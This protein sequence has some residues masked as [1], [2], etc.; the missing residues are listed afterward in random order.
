MYTSAIAHAPSALSL[1]DSFFGA[2]FAAPARGPSS[3][4]L[5]V[6]EKDGVITVRAALPGLKRGDIAISVHEGVLR[7]EAADGARAEASDE[8]GRWLR[9]EVASSRALSGAWS[10]RLRLPED[11]DAAAITAALADGVLTL[12]LP[13]AEKPAPRVIEII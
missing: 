7:I 13:R 10:R 9:R 12:T 4:P 8:D 3:L 6:Y 1:F 11:V 2:P 5:D